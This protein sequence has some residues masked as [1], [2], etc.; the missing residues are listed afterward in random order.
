MTL[1]DHIDLVR[2]SFLDDAEDGQRLSV[3]I[4]KA[5]EAFKEDLEKDPTR[6]EFI[7]TSNDDQIEDIPSCNE[8]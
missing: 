7:C 5:L 4:V 6:R 1:I 3:N 2:R 8:I